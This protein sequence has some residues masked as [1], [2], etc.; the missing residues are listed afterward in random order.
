[1]AIILAGL[2]TAAA[3]QPSDLQA[4]AALS[5][6]SREISAGEVFKM[7]EAFVAEGR[8]SDA[9][10][11]LRGIIHDASLDYRSEGRFRLGG[12]RAAQGDLAGAIRWYRALLDE[13]PDAVAVRLELARIYMLTGSEAAARREL[14][15]ASAI[16]LPEDVLRVVDQFALALRSRRQL[17]GSLE[18][19]VA[20]DSNVNRATSAKTINTVLGPLVPDTN[21]KA[22]SGIGLAIRA[23]GF[24]RSSDGDSPILVRLSGQG[25]LYGRNQFN[26]VALSAAIGPELR[27]GGVRWRPALLNNRRWFGGD[28]YSEHRGATVNWLTNLSPTAQLE[29]EGMMAYGSYRRAAQSGMVYDLSVN[30]DR[31][32][33]KNLSFRLKAGAT[34]VEARDPGFAT[35]S[36]TLGGIVA[37]RLGGQTLLIDASLSR[38]LR[39]NGNRSSCGS[40]GIGG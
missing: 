37:R 39:T 4:T 5:S 21:A 7:A 32:V 17:G 36:G 1:M 16:G 9:E 34:R 27:R 15:R 8:L 22:T 33:G 12:L 30:Y 13:K 6:A 3:I 14:R 40:A 23:Q 20:P 2:L 24:W 19:N 26:D 31:A 11:L 25:D 29:V 35:V 28:R 38:L 10:T 18:L